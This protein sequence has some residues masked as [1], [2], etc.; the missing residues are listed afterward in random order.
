MSRLIGRKKGRTATTAAVL[1]H[2]GNSKP[3]A[4]GA[5]QLSPHLMDIYERFPLGFTRRKAFAF[6]G[7][8][9]SIQGRGGGGSCACLGR[10]PGWG[11]RDWEG[12]GVQGD[13]NWGD[14]RALYNKGQMWLNREHIM[15][16]VVG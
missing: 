8:S 14:D 12:P 1:S 13:N 11:L 16:R 15:G 4:D 5:L 3:V 6:Q 10:L 9:S 7:R 2:V